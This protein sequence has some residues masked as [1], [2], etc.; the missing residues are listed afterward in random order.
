MEK[1]VEKIRRLLQSRYETKLDAGLHKAEKDA[2]PFLKEIDNINKRK[3]QLEK[4]S[5]I[6]EKILKK[7]IGTGYGIINSD[8]L[9]PKIYV[10]TNPELPDATTR[11][12]E[13]LN[14]TV[15]IQGFKSEETQKQIK[16]LFDSF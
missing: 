5:K 10:L 1:Q 9:K 11:Q 7:K 2:K 3:E 13:K 15:I 4:Q 14:E 16:K 6:V 8:W 12:L